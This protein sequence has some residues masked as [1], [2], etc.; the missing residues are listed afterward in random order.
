MQAQMQAQAEAGKMQLEREKLQLEAAK[1][2]MEAQKIEVDRLKVQADV[3]KAQMAQQPQADI[4]AVAQRLMNL[5]QI[6]AELIQTLRGASAPPQD[7]AAQP[8]A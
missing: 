8:V 2:Q 6:T 1:L 5:E 4:G 3:V 7:F